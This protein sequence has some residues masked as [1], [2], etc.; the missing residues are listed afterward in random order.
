MTTNTVAIVEITLAM[1]RSPK[2]VW[3][4]SNDLDHQKRLGVIFTSLVQLKQL[5]NQ[6]DKCL[7]TAKKPNSNSSNAKLLSGT[8]RPQI[9]AIVAFISS[10][11][12]YML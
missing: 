4:G 10:D 2:G 5:I 1:K 9:V 12:P 7:A 8:R 6:V 3:A 11:F